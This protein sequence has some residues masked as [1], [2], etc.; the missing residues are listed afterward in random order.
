[1]FTTQTQVIQKGKSALHY[2]IIPWDSEYLH[3]TTIEIEQFTVPSKAILKKLIDQLCHK[4]TLKKGDLLVS[5]IPLENYA[6][7]LMLHQIGFYYMEQATTLDIDL[8]LW[9][10]KMFTFP[11]EDQ[12]QLIQANAADQKAIQH[13]AQTTFTAD[14]YHLDPRIPKKYADYR[15]KKWIENSFNNKDTI[16]TCIDNTHTI[17]GFFIVNEQK[18]YAE[19][20]LAGL[21]NAYKGKG[22][23]KML[24]HHMYQILKEK[25]FTRI[26][27]VISLN[28]I[29]V[30]NV[31]MY[32]TQAKFTKPLIVLHNVL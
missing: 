24:Y 19:F 16:Y 1:M 28:N 27:S 8:S 15:F 4:H 21:H 13:I 5:K 20:R 22:L 18:E 17:I 9:N 11:N 32:L 26:A 7:A 29:Q 25:K 23:G 12:Y 10:G 3:N 2:T 6:K 30:M 31:Y 14:R